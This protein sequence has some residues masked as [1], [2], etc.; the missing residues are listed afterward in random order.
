[1]LQANYS[2]FPLYILNKLIYILVNFMFF[3]Q[4]IISDFIFR[5]PKLYF[6]RK[7]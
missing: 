6:P 7:S 1:M 2:I 4:L 3:M 5:I